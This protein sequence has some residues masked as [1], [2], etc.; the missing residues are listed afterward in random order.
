[1]R[2]IILTAIGVAMFAA[3]L[4]ADTPQAGIA[5]HEKN[6]YGLDWQAPDILV[7]A[8][9][10]QRFVVTPSGVTQSFGLTLGTN[11]V[12]SYSLSPYSAWPNQDLQDR[13]APIHR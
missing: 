11:S 9:F 12:G 7:P 2:K 5:Q 4:A 8:G 13:Y 10:P 6:R 3:P 1:M